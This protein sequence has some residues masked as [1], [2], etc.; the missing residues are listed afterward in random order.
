[1]RK[2]TWIPVLCMLLVLLA[3]CGKSPSSQTSENPGNVYR[4]ITVDEKGEPVPGTA[5]QFCSESLCVMGE[6]GED[7]I[8]VFEDR[9]EGTYTVRI[10]KVPEGYAEDK[11]EYAVPET[12]GDMTITL[13]A[14]G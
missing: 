9:E 8:A 3:A 6:T 7:G 1:M 14:A 10:L 13:K 4:V 12:F 5:L 2:K 11:T